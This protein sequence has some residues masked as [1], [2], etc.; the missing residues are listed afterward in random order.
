[1]TQAVIVPLLYQTALLYRSPSAT[2][3]YFSEAYG[4]YDYSMIG[5]TN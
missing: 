5:S 1:M 4:M 3:V 2:N